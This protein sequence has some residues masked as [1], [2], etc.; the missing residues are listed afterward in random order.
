MYEA[1]TKTLLIL[2][3]KS[4][5]RQVRGSKWKYSGEIFHTIWKSLC[6]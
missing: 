2:K 3:K 6:I 4:V 1:K 5:L